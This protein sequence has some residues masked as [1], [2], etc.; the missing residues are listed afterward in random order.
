MRK[1]PRSPVISTLSRMLSQEYRVR[2][3]GKETVRCS[4]GNFSC[5]VPCYYDPG[6]K[7]FTA[8]LGDLALRGGFPSRLT[9]AEAAKVEKALV[10]A[11]GVR[12]LFGL[13]IGRKDVYVQRQQQVS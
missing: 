10:E 12:R 5:E 13:A 7:A 8:V 4:A 3:I 1:K 2:W 6:R 9:D 11:I